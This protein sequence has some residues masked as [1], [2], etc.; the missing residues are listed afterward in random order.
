MLPP[1]PPRAVFFAPGLPS[2]RPL[3]S[4]GF[5]SVPWPVDYSSG[6]STRRDA[7]LDQRWM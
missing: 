5:L 7:Y 6:W 1:I 3:W 2:L 4:A